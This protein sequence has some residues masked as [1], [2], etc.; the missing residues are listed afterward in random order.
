MI[1]HFFQKGKRN[2]LPKMP[3]SLASGSGRR[4]DALATHRQNHVRGCTWQMRQTKSLGNDSASCSP[5]FSFSKGFVEYENED[6]D[7]DDETES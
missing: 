6:E 1:T 2:F 7:E 5:S 4:I 3:S